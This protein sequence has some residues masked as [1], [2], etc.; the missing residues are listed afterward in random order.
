MGVNGE[1]VAATY[2]G[3]VS[4]FLEVREPFVKNNQDQVQV[5]TVYMEMN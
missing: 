1:T 5:G 2:P 3:G 4:N